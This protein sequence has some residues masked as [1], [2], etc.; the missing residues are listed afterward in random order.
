MT[1]LAIL[2]ILFAIA[3]VFGWISARW[4]KLPTTIGTMLLTVLSSMAL[5]GAGTHAPAVRAWAVALSDQIDLRG[6]ILHGMLPLLLFAGAFLLDLEQLRKEKF[7]V[8]L[9]AILGTVISVFL[10]AG[11][12]GVL[13]GWRAPWIEYLLFGALISPTDPVAVLEM[14][15]RTRAPKAIHAQ[16]AGESLFNDGVGAVIFITLLEAARGTQPTVWSISGALLLKAGGGLLL[17]VAG[18]AVAS[19]LMRRLTS[20][21]VDILITIALA[22]GGYAIAEVLR[23]SAPLEAVA[24]GIALRS[25]NRNQPAETIAHDSVHGFW[26]LID[27]VQNSLLFVLL[28]L[29]IM[30]VTLDR[31]SL[32][33]GAS[34]IL[35]VNVVRLVAVGMLLGVLRLL[36]PSHRSSMLVLVWGGLR[37]GLSI[38]L[39]LSVPEGLGR[40]W[41]L[42]ATYV[43]VV[44]SILVQGGSLNWLLGW[45]SRRRAAARP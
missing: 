45:Q 31:N 39:A 38:A 5:M 9:L 8:A 24:A 4:L 34:A 1:N 18:A 32:G 14:L 10:V 15:R 42:A 44:F 41:I 17:G 33:E 30:T 7:A 25:F 13:G 11:L 40:T 23:I 3:A 28:G 20:Y 36:Q 26:S 12:M 16:L 37:G 27:E 6:V 43:V 29:A 22:F 35:V 21:Q 2:S 19:Q